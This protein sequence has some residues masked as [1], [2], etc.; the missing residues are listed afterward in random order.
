M[1]HRLFSLSKVTDNKRQRTKEGLRRN[2]LTFYEAVGVIGTADGKDDKD[3]RKK[4]E[5]QMDVTR[6]R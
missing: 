5:P 1:Y 2:T 6:H 4:T 3:E